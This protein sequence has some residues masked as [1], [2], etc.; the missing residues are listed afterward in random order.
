MSAPSTLISMYLSDFADPGMDPSA[1]GSTKLSLLLTPSTWIQRATRE[2]REFR[3][4]A[5]F[6]HRMLAASISTRLDSTW[7]LSAHTRIGRSIAW[8]GRHSLIGRT[9]DRRHQ[10]EV[11]HDRGEKAQPAEGSQAIDPKRVYGVSLLTSV[12]Q[13]VPVLGVPT[14]SQGPGSVAADGFRFRGVRTR[15]M[16]SA[17]AVT[18]VPVQAVVAY[19][20]LAGKTAPAGV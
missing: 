15:V 12:S 4:A 9:M 8:Q 17:R 19:P 13:S 11:P 7:R 1:H 20:P 6:Q 18:A 2:P 14:L 16:M 10:K 3:R 5:A